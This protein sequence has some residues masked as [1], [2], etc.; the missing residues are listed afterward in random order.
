MARKPVSTKGASA[1]DTVSSVSGR[2]TQGAPAKAAKPK[3]KAAAPIADPAPKP[4]AAAVTTAPADV[5]RAVPGPAADAAQGARF[6]RQ[7]LISA[8]AARSDL[9]RS[10]IKDVVDLVLEEVGRA[11]DAGD[12]LVLP[13]LGKLLVKKRLEGGTGASVL[14][15]KLRRTPPKGAG[16][17]MAKTP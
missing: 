15:V 1:A 5:H 4:R 2:R 13:P 9:K 10:E 11:A 12:T 16:G 6:R 8:I 7:D 14:T 3:A 17:A